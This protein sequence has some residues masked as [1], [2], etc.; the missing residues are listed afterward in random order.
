HVR[1][2]VLR[3]AAELAAAVY[4]HILDV[5]VAFY[6]KG[7][8]IYTDV[9]DVRGERVTSRV[10]AI[11]VPAAVSASGRVLLAY[12]SQR[13]IENALAKPLPRFTER[14]R[15][16]PVEILDL[17]RIIR[18]RGYDIADGDTNPAISGVAFPIF[19]AE[20][21]AVSALSVATAGPARSD[22]I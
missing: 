18:E 1:T 15:T 16:S 5:L 22:V 9:L 10:Q 21:R 3:A 11:R 8:V 2:V 13:E 12:Q 6:E 4:S 20:N 14:T 17:L 19:D 7:D